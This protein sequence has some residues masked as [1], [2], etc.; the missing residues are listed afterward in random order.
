MELYLGSPH[1]VVLYTHGQNYITFTLTYAVQ[2]ASI[3]TQRKGYEGCTFVC[4]KS[5]STRSF[6]EDDVEGNVTNSGY[7]VRTPVSL[8][9]YFTEVERDDITR[10]NY[11]VLTQYVPYFCEKM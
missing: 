8:V 6:S 5:T 2:I 11:Y 4:I 9:A 10:S 1:A 7:T 3:N